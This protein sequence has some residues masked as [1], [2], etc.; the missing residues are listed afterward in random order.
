MDWPTMFLHQ[1]AWNIVALRILRAKGL[2]FEWF[3]ECSERGCPSYAELSNKRD[4]RYVLTSVYSRGLLLQT[5]T[6]LT[7]TGNH[8]QT[9][10]FP[11][12][13]KSPIFKP[14]SLPICLN[15]YIHRCLHDVPTHLR[16][17]IT[18]YIY[19]FMKQYY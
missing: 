7:G 2:C 18:T 5:I 19:I 6:V 10:P 3:P 14:P 1:L 13:M 15:I 8:L 16:T 11:I 12:C 17:C 9:G 4:L